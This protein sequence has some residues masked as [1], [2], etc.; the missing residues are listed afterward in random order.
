MLLLLGD[1]GNVEA[2]VLTPEYN[3]NDEERPSQVTKERDNPM[4][5]HLIPRQPALES[6]DSGELV[7][8]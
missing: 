2:I 8:I 3:A 1:F 6:S 4:N 5:Q 7:I